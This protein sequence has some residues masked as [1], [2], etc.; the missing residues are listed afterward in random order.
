MFK[1]NKFIVF[2]SILS[3]AI[4]ATLVLSMVLFSFNA[5]NTLKN[6]MKQAYGEMDLS[7]GFNM[8][9]SNVLTPKLV[10][11]IVQ[12]KKVNKVS[13]VSIAHLNVNKMDTAIYTVGAE[14][15]YLPK[16]RYHFTEDLNEESVVMNKGL[17]KV[18]HAK[19]G[20]KIL[21]ENKKYTLVETVDDLTA[22]G[23]APDM[24]ILNQKVVKSYIQAKDNRKA[25]ATYLLIKAKKN[26]NT[27]T[28]ANQIKSYD[29]DLHIDI[30]E[31]DYGVK[32][33]L[34]SLHLF[35]V[36]LSV[37]VL[38]VTSLIIISNFELLLYKM[39]NQFA[40]MRSL[41]ASTKQISK[42]IMIQ[43][44]VINITGISLGFILNFL[45]Q[46]TLYSWVEKLFN[47]PTTPSEFNVGAA[48]SI[49]ILAFIV[50]Q[51]FLFVP[52][53][54]S[55]KVLPLKTMEE[56]EKLNYSYSKVRVTLS[57][58]L[59]GIAVFLI[60]G[61]QVLPTRGTYGPAM[62]LISAVLVLL[63][64][65]L[66]FPI[67]L[68]KILEWFFLPYGQRLFGQEFYISVKNLIPQVR[69]NTAIILMISSLMII[70]VFGSVTLRT[71]QISQLEQ[72]KKDFATPILIETRIDNSKINSME[73][74]KTV[75]ELSGVKSV[76][77]FSTLGLAELQTE[78]KKVDMNYAVVDLKRLQAQGL[79]AHLNSKTPSNGLI[80]SE[81]FA[82]QSHLKVGQTVPV[83][84][85]SNETQIVESKGT[86]KVIA[87]EKQLLNNADA[88]VDWNNQ[89]LLDVIFYT[90]YVDSE[91][92]KNTVNELEELKSQYPEIKISNYE[93]SVKEANKMFYQ[94]WGIFILVIATLVASTMV[95]VF[96]SLAN[97]I[98][99]K[100]KE[101]A[102][103]RAMGVTPKGLRKVILSQVNL[104]IGIG[105]IIGIIMGLLTTFILLLVDPGEFVIDYK[106]IIT[107]SLLMLAGSTLIFWFVGNKILSQELSIELTNDN[108]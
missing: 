27:L 47:I 87:I 26:V 65:V 84:E 49:S 68:P 8:D 46:R 102:V 82:Q 17:A 3:I 33:N 89:K 81:R 78:G 22:T 75:E 64:F 7:V 96:N 18:L 77:N 86:F 50:I 20:D 4:S 25:E 63:A 32:S 40:I 5:Q 91:H 73:F 21:I 71:I 48:I 107:V 51:L 69:K 39:R 1:A 23:S 10:N 53:Y 2:S 105:L 94:R 6:Q 85:F 80:L 92:I 59:V 90:L 99:S 30:A 56:N 72:L 104:Y 97:N 36:V 108:K 100:R 93:Q 12:N 62:L 76:S 44:T 58:V 74:T 19:I 37:L 79:M 38:I 83:G 9:Q 16:S 11:E 55:T 54:R 61:S 101:F 31:Q 45:S 57:K 103:L 52:A 24:L 66:V 42:I 28:L 34:Q 67:W 60:I 15:N 88:Y 41:G 95:G 35:I 14:N 98:Y 13:K 106:V 43:S 29:K 70:A